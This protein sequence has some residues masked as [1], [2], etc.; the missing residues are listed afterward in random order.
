MTENEYYEQ[1][2]ESFH[3]NKD[4]FVFK[5]QG[6][7]ESGNCFNATI[8]IPKQPF[9]RIQQDFA[10]TNK[11]NIVQK[12]SLPLWFKELTTSARKQFKEIW[13][14][15]IDGKPKKLKNNYI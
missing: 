2:L 3:G 11:E 14:P 12:E 1:H 8:A 4:F 13:W 7:L 15:L 5:Y 10:I 6:T 9:Y